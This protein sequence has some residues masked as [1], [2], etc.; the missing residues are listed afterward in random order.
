MIFG[1]HWSPWTVTSTF[2]GLMSRW[3]IPFWWAC[4]MPSQTSMKSF[5]RSRTVSRLVS[6]YSVMGIPWTYSIAK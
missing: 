1:A 5:R 2:D 6:Q 4:W 3:M